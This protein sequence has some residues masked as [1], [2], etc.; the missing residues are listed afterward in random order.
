PQEL[1]LMPTMTVA[2]HF[3]YYGRLNEMNTREIGKKSA[4]LMELLQI[5]SMERP[6]E[7]L[8]GGQ[9]RRTSLALTLLHSPPLLVLDEPTVGIDPVLRNK[10]WMYLQELTV[11]ESKTVS[12]SVQVRAFPFLP[13]VSFHR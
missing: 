5:P 3:Q 11:R 4:Y 8:S 7:R 13:L 1:A 2:D 10:I 9:Q 12:V 6:V